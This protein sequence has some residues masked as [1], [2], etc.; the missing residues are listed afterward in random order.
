MHP[1]DFTR[2]N[3]AAVRYPINKKKL[4]IPKLRLPSYKNDETHA[5]EATQA[6]RA[7]MGRSLDA[8]HSRLSRFIKAQSTKTPSSGGKHSL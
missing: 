3:E 2:H 5:V 4:T 7:A 1:P 8:S 6:T